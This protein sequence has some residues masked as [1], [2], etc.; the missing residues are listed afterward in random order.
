[1]ADSSSFRSLATPKPEKY[2]A[3]VFLE[4]RYQEAQKSSESSRFSLR[5]PVFKAGRRTERMTMA[6]EV[7]SP[8]LEKAGARSQHVWTSVAAADG[9][10]LLYHVSWTGPGN[11]W[12]ADV[13]NTLGVM[14]DMMYALDDKGEELKAP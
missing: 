10:V 11:R 8:D 2:S 7:V 14:V 9:S 4:D 3:E 5:K 6:Y 12:S 1:M 13:E